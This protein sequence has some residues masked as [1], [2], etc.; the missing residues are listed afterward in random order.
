MILVVVAVALYGQVRASPVLPSPSPRPDA[1]PPADALTP[2]AL[3]PLRPATSAEIARA[4]PLPLT[5][6]VRQELP[7]LL[8]HLPA[9]GTAAIA[10]GQTTVVVYLPPTLQAQVASGAARLMNSSAVPG[11]V[12]GAVQ[13]VNTGKLLGQATLTSTRPLLAVAGWQ[14][15]SIAVAQA[16]LQS[17]DRRLASLDE[18]VARIERWLLDD[19]LAGLDADYAHLTRIADTLR[20]HAP[21]DADRA[22]WAVTLEAIERDSARRMGQLRRALAPPPAGSVNTWAPGTLTARID[23]LRAHAEQTGTLTDAFALA[24]AV[25]LVAASLRPACGLHAA[26]AEAIREDV[27]ETLHDWAGHA[28]RPTLDT[29]HH[30]ATSASARFTTAAYQATVRDQARTAHD[31]LAAQIRALPDLADPADLWAPDPRRPQHLLLTLDSDGQV[32]GLAADGG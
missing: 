26:H 11:G 15:L 3:P 23:A 12:Y 29:L 4:R 6:A 2:P 20:H 9:L 7:G 21:S 16:H 8:A 32:M 18:R 25:R 5:P 24:A 14:L 10:A 28:A 17:I 31:A 30:A 27:A 19:L 1:P 13:D 22:G